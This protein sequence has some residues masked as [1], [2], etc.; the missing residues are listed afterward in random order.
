MS[1]VNESNV[2]A[3]PKPSYCELNEEALDI[4]AGGWLPYATSYRLPDPGSILRLN[5][6]GS[7]PNS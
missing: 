7:Q 5:T 4:V 2:N 6:G 1:N 3:E